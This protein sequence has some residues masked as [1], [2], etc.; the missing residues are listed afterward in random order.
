MVKTKYNKR[1]SCFYRPNKIEFKVGQIK[2]PTIATCNPSGL[3]TQTD[4]L[5][6]KFTIDEFWFQVQIS[7]N[8]KMIFYNFK[9]VINWRG[10]NITGNAVQVCAVTPEKLSYCRLELFKRWDLFEG[11]I[12]REKKPK[13]IWNNVYL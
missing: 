7:M 3:T 4:Q 11:D 2:L 13:F 6:T 10:R 12:V 1:C 5:I 9:G 8:F